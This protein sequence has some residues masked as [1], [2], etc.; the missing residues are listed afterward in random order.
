MVILVDGFRS[1]WGKDLKRVYSIYVLQCRGTFFKD[2][3]F[4]LH[5]SGLG[6]LNCLR[7]GNW[8]SE[9]DSLLCRLKPVFTP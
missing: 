2:T 6:S 7:S 3:K 5:L 4:S 9:H 1:L 8:V